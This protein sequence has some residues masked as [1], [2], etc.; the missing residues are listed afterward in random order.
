MILISQ[1]KRLDLLKLVSNKI[2]K[3][4]FKKRKK[5]F[6]ITLQSS[7]V[8]YI[9]LISTPKRNQEGMMQQS[10]IGVNLQFQ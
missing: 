6:R 4:I 7:V 9:F 1:I 10:S 2:K 3:Y 5:D 8:I